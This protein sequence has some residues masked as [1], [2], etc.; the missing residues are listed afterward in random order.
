M[1]GW[2]SSSE[3]RQERTKRTFSHVQPEFMF[4]SSQ[5]S[6]S[7]CLCI[8]S[9]LPFLRFFIFFSSFLLFIFVSSSAFLHLRFFAFVSSFSVLPLRFF[10]LFFIF[11]SSSSFLR[12][13]PL[14]PF[15]QIC[16]FIFVS[17]FLFL[18]FHFFS[19][20]CS[21]LCNF[22]GLYTCVWVY[23]CGRLLL[24]ILIYSS[25]TVFIC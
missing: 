8:A 21:L 6:V 23:V 10:A 18:C 9:S 3:E 25:F 2:R 7:V 12:F 24:F 14:F 17:S 1:V 11:V 20:V 13:F 19:F 16:F 22:V 4:I 5:L 15:L